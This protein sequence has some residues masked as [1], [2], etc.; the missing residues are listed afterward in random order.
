[1]SGLSYAQYAA[2]VVSATISSSISITCSSL[3]IYIACKRSI[4]HLYH[5]TVLVLSVADILFSVSNI[6][7]PYLL[8]KGTP[9][10]R[11]ARGNTQTCSAAGFFLN[12]FPLFVAMMNAFLSIYFLL[13]VRYSWKD[14]RIKRLEIPAYSVGFS[15]IWPLSVLGF[16]YREC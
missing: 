15:I 11:W 9:G 3:I 8:P 2:L 12:F 16:F 4:D 5:R 7:H 10:L 6:I 14:A 13:V 1:M